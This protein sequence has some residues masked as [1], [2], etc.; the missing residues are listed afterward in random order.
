MIQRIRFGSWSQL[1][2]E[3]TH[4]NGTR[5]MGQNWM[6]FEVINVLILSTEE[7]EAVHFLRIKY[8]NV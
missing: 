3:N 1:W 8:L 2:S 7:A 6:L 4:G 5:D